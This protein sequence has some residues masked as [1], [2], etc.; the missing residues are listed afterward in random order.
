MISQEFYGYRWRFQSKT[1]MIN[2]LGVF[3]V[4]ILPGVF[5]RPVV[6][7]EPVL[8]SDHRG[9]NIVAHEVC[10]MFWSLPLHKSRL[11]GIS[12]GNHLSWGR[13]NTCTNQKLEFIIRYCQS[14]TKL[15]EEAVN[16]CSEG[17]HRG[18]HITYTGATRLVP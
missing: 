9:I 15:G 3:C 11:F 12:G 17:D 2:N 18:F 16:G 10:G 13:R 14:L 1:H 8:G 7:R 5:V 6:T 4:R